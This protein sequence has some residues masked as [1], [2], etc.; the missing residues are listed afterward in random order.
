[1]KEKC[2]LCG[3]NL[4]QKNVNFDIWVKDN[5]FIF[6]EVPA[7]VCDQ[8]DEKYL[9][10]NTYE[11]INLSLKNKNLEVKETITVPVIDF[12]EIPTLT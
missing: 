8:C 1:M 4:E 7:K 6:K 10:A 11:E 9:S 3:G 2:Q 5:L 12:S